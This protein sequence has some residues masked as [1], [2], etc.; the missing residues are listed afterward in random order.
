MGSTV[1][2]A[3]KKIF[4]RRG[5]TLIEIMLVIALLG[6]LVVAGFGAFTSS[7][8][9]GRDAKRK[10]DLNQITKALGMY[11]NDAGRYPDAT[12]GAIVGCVP[13]AGGAAQVCAWGSVFQNANTAT[14]YMAQLPTDPSSGKSYFYYA[15][16]GGSSYYLLARLENKEDAAIPRLTPGDP[17]TNLYYSSLSADC[18]EPSECNF[19]VSSVNVSTSSITTVDDP[20]W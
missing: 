1:H 15:P 11:Y 13:A 14:V 12:N 8:A 9:R 19:A 17:D 2:I 5:F 3:M 20:N 18:G 10:G 16:A 6:I 4:P 7:L